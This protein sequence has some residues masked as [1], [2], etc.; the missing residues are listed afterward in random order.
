[1]QITH[2]LLFVFDCLLGDE[3]HPLTGNA[4]CSIFLILKRFAQPFV[5]IFFIS[6]VCQEYLVNNEIKT[7]IL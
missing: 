5:Q 4:P 7:T 1:M 6:Y 2:L 3:C